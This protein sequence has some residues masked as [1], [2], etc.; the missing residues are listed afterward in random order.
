MA[1]KAKEHSTNTDQTASSKGREDVRAEQALETLASLNNELTKAHLELKNAYEISELEVLA[2]DNLDDAKDLWL[3]FEEKAVCFVYQQFAFCQT[4]YETVGKHDNVK[5]HIVVIR[6]GQSETL[7]LLPLCFKKGHFGQIVQFI[8]Y[9]M[10]DYLSP[11]VQKDFADNVSESDFHALWDKVVSTIKGNA[12]LFWLDRQPLSINGCQNPMIHLEHFNYASSAH[13]LNFPEAE[14]WAQ[15]ARILRSKKTAAN[16]ERRLRKLAKEGEIELREITGATQ[17]QSHMDELLALKIENLNA[18]GTIHRMTDPG[19]ARFYQ[20][21]ASIES[22][23]KV[24]RQFELRC[25]D[26]LV[27][28]VLGYVHHDTFYYQICAFNRQEFAQYSPG[29]LLLYLLFDWSFSLGLKRFDM[30][31]GDESYKADWRNETTP[32]VTVGVANSKTGRLE[33][34]LRRLIVWG[35]TQVHNTDFLRKLALAV[36]HKQNA[37]KNT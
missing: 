22:Q 1:G 9:G 19:Y 37:L 30:T 29:L 35:K 8:G 36:L 15:C 27:A 33:Y 11:L 5:P 2:F 32:L 6:N 13:A 12:D 31:I 16:I 21:L 18:A 26:K 10:A 24:V 4:W 17:R 34:G 28:S 20:S 3:A 7:M 23:Q 25:G 14:N